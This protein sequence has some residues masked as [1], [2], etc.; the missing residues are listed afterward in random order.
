[1]ANVLNMPKVRGVHTHMSTWVR[2]KSG[3]K[4]FLA[5]SYEKLYVTY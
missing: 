2:I 3:I 5:H 4:S 1:M